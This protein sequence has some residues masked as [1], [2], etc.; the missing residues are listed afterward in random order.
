MASIFIV[1]VTLV[2]ASVIPL[3]WQHCPTWSDAIFSSQFWDTLRCSW[4]CAQGLEISLRGDMLDYVPEALGH[5]RQEITICLAAWCCQSTHS[6]TWLYCY[7]WN[8]CWKDHPFCTSIIFAWFL[9]QDSYHYIASKCS[10]NW[11]CDCWW[12][13]LVSVLHSCAAVLSRNSSESVSYL[14]KCL[15][16]FGRY[17]SIKN[18]L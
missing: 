2:Y 5:F 4:G 17:R 10:R 12:C 6:W 9:R 8:W 1:I 14:L 3:L 11:T 15:G 13:G 16:V 18:M 7:C